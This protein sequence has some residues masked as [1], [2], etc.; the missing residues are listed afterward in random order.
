MVSLTQYW[1]SFQYPNTV[2]I[3]SAKGIVVIVTIL[4]IELIPMP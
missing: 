4:I 2:I 1:S 3:L